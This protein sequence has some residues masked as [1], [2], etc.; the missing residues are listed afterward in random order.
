MVGRVLNEAL[1]RHCM[2]NEYDM[3]ISLFTNEVD[4]AIMSKIN[5][6]AKCS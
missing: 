2:L 6:K 5:N 1:Q 4:K 3:T